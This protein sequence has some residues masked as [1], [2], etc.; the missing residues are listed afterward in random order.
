V[1]TL[2]P[3]TGSNY[4]IQAWLIGRGSMSP[5]PGSVVVPI[6]SNRAF[7]FTASN[8][9]DIA[10]VLVDET[11]V[12]TNAAYTF[13]NVV[14]NHDIG[15]TFTDR[16]AASNTPIWWLAQYGLTNNFNVEATNDQD[17]DRMWTWQEYIAGTVPTNPA[18]VFQIVRVTHDASGNQLYWLSSQGRVYSVYKSS[19]ILGAWPGQALTNNLP[20]DASGTNNW[21]D[22][23]Y[24]PRAWYRIGVSVGQ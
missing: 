2:I 4:L 15:V 6:H 7:T 23:N 18:S 8:Y 13:T 1:V 16:L 24:D 3:P 19:D 11:S 14:M 12:G 21:M 10:D 5:G 9:S 22:Q 17:H 20:Y